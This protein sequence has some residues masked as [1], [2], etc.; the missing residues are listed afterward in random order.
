MLK[1]IDCNVENQYDKNLLQYRCGVAHNLESGN[2]YIETI[3][4]EYVN[5]D[6][7]VSW[8]LVD[9]NGKVLVKQI[10]NYDHIYIL[11]IETRQFEY[12]KIEEI[13]GE[14]EQVHI[15]E[16]VNLI[17]KFS[18]RN[19]NVR[20]YWNLNKGEVRCTNIIYDIM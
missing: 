1:R 10:H 20:I 11:N 16:I 9:N 6:L 7:P 8:Y 4:G 15:Y 19:P 14:I 18:A 3:P 12:S 5:D 17:K 2:I 13:D